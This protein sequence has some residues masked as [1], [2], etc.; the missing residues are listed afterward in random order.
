MT[1]FS[2][3][4]KYNVEYSGY[5]DAS[6]ALRERLA[7]V[8]GK[9]ISSEGFFDNSY[10]KD[11]IGYDEFIHEVQKHTLKTDPFNL[12]KTAPFHE[13]FTVVEIYWDLASSLDGQ[14][15]IEIATAL[16]QTFSLSGSVYQI[17]RDGQIALVLNKE[18][19][20][21]IKET[22]KILEPYASA[23]KTFFEAVG[24]LAGKKTKPGDIVRD[25]YV[26]AEGY[27]KAITG[28]A[29]YSSAVKKLT[30]AGAINNEQKSIMEKLYAFRSNTHGT[31]H[32]GSAPEPNEK[33][34]LWF[35]DTMSAQLR[36]IEIQAKEGEI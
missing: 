31:T 2:H 32:A 22:E 10:S 18:L 17:N 14:R 26:A 33:D 21:K 34:A 3:R 19:S 35:L 23:Y 24:N 30:N 5:E 20:E 8:M 4:N 9:Y 36:H 16:R 29:Q 13:V 15:P 1:Y 12:V 27:L 6:T 11:W 7:S 25:I 28:E